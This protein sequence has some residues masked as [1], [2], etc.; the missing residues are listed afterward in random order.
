M[1]KII[2]GAFLL[3]SLKSVILP[4]MASSVALFA[5]SAVLGYI[6]FLNSNKKQEA[7]SYLTAELAL[8]KDEVSSLKAQQVFKGIAR[9]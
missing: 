9:R 4:D 6:T 3:L 1:E 2:I 5:V 7:T 8:L